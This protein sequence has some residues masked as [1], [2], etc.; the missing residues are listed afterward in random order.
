[1]CRC[2]A[3]DAA[4]RRACHSGMRH[5]C[6]A[7][8]ARMLH[9]TFPSFP[10]PPPCTHLPPQDDALVR[11]LHAPAVQKPPPPPVHKNQSVPQTARA[12]CQRPHAHLLGQDD[13]GNHL[14]VDGRR[15]GASLQQPSHVDAPAATKWPQARREPP[16]Q[17]PWPIQGQM[18]RAHAW[19]SKAR[20]KADSSGSRWQQSH[21]SL[22]TRP[23]TRHCTSSLPLTGPAAAPSAAR[24]HRRRWPAAAARPAAASCG[25]S[26][27]AAWCSNTCLSTMQL[28]SAW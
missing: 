26:S 8:P 9:N 7:P 14:V 20:R 17:K 27:A 10:L 11:C 12:G 13:A 16:L 18:I 19:H 6:T 1:M 28:W 3:W 15:S 25:I 24:S 21:H 22:P 2:S 23:D 4:C 5:H